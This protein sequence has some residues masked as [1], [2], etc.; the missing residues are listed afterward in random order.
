MRVRR[1]WGASALIACLL[2]IP[3]ASSAQNVSIRD[4]PLKPW[5]GL[6]RSWDWMYDALHTLVLSGITGP[7]V[8]NTK[9]MSRREMALIVADVV[10]RVQQGQVAPFE[11][12]YDLQDVLLDLMAEL[13]PELSALGLEGPGVTGQPPRLLEIRPLQYLQF[14]A[15]Y[16]SQ[17]PTNLE[18]RNGERLE[19]GGSLR[20]ATASWMEVGGMFAAYANPEFLWGPDELSGRLVEGY[21]K[22]RA[23][24]FELLFGN[25]ALWWGPGFHGS[26]LFSNNPLS[27]T[28]IR[29]QTATQVVLPGI[30]RYLGP[31][32]AAVLFGQF[33]R[34]REFP[35]AKLAGFR[36]DLAP[37]QWLEI[38]LGRTVTF[39]GDGHAQP[40][41]YQWPGVFF[42]GNKAGTEND[43]F[44]GNNISQVDVTIRLADVGRYVPITQDAEIY[45]DFGVDDTCCGTFFVPLKPGAIVGLYLPNLFQRPD[46]TLRLEYSNTSSFNFTH[47]TW[48][49]GYSR[50]GR[51]LSHFEGTVG[52]DFFVRLTHR[53]DKNLEV[54][55]EYDQARIGSTVKGQEFKTKELNRHFGVDVSYVHEKRL[56]LTLGARLEWVRNRGF[57]A[58]E[59]DIN[60]VYTMEATYMFDAGFGAG[61]RSAASPPATRA[62]SRTDGAPDPDQIFSWDYVRKTGQDAW[63]LLKAPLSWGP[64]EWL[65][66]G[67]AVAATGAAMLLDHEARD[68]ALSNQTTTGG[69]IANAMKYFGTAVPLGVIAGSYVF[70]E[71]TKNLTAKRLA[72]DGLEAS[73]LSSLMVVYPMKFL[74]GRSRPSENRGSQD[75]HPFNISGSLPS[76]HTAEAFTMA[77]VVAE[78]ADNPWV[79]ALAYG[80]AAGVGVSRVYDDRHWVSDVVASAVIGTVVGKAV[81]ALNR[82][83]RDAPVSVVP[84]AAPGS[85][86]A[87]LQFRY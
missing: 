86:G 58:G 4:V 49:D 50:K 48:T 24:P 13:G 67:G 61:A 44:A 80:L 45:L 30:F 23:G 77:A 34:E 76:S 38:G 57:V 1:S 25:E 3:I 85:W 53:L 64:T 81:V 11:H 36:L 21:M 52:E 41:W 39:G 55:V 79:S 42:F 16:A 20:V 37:F 10:R 9:P 75:Y 2:L 87:A 35:R 32:K 19:E 33:E 84:L 7:V 5:T 68:W 47:G 73:I 59:Y 15:N 46:T 62:D 83:R 22:G 29:L 56:N 74:L 14:R 60:Q 78:H 72:A 28:M 40:P 26:M 63:S 31:M 18:N 43:E 71:Y 70:G 8:L 17:A 69:E 51:P 66:A 12:R 6:A 82:Q 54:G 65:L 27:L